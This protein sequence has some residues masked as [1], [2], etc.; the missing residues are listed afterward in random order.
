MDELEQ[1][2]QA[3]EEAEA[4]KKAFVKSNATGEGDPTERS[5]LYIDVEKARKALREYKLQ[6]PEL[7]R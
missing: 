7:L 4:R 5:R 2:E 3:I 1:L 6:H